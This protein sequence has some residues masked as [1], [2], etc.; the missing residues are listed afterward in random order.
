MTFERISR[1]KRNRPVPQV[2]LHLPTSSFL[3]LSSHGETASSP[4]EIKS[5]NDRQWEVERLHRHKRFGGGM[6]GMRPPWTNWSAN[7]RPNVDV[8]STDRK[9]ACNMN[10]KGPPSCI[11]SDE[12]EWA[13]HARTFLRTSGRGRVYRGA[14]CVRRILA[15]WA[16]LTAE[17]DGCLQK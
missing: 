6:T 9:P 16:R 17:R 1:C 14:E 5:C 7:S 2:L 15:D 13:V 10:P 12:V 8:M 11:S 3:P 4:V